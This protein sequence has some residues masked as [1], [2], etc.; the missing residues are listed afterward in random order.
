[1]IDFNIKSG[2][3]VINSDLDII[4]QQIDLLFDTNRGEVLGDEA[5]GTQYDKYLY[6]LNISNEGLRSEVLSD[7]NK[8][9]LFGFIPN[10]EVFML[11]GTEQDIAIIN[12]QLSRDRE[13]YEKTYKI[14]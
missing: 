4:L 11:Q 3:G 7:L 6:K 5:F 12:I 10:V 9:E 8:I 14:S 2:S 13:I 1:M